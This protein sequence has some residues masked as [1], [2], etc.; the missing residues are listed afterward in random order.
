MIKY[1]EKLLFEKTE[2]KQSNILFAQWNYDKKVIPEALNAVSN[3]FPHYSLHDESHSIT[4]INNIVRVLGKEKIKNLSSIDIWLLLEASYSHDIGM[5][6]SHE[7][8]IE[9]LGSTE[10]LDFFTEIQQDS[11]NGLNE[12]AT[13]FILKNKRLEYIS[14]ELNLN[15]HDGIKFILAEFFRRKHSDRSKEII[16]N[17]EKELGLTS[18]R[19]VIPNRL[20]KIL[21]D[22]CESHTKNFE[23]VMKLPFCEV[24][25]D[26]ENSHPRF[27][28]CLL[29]IGDLLDLDN[30]RFSEVMLRTLSKT[31]IDTLSHKAKHLSIQSFRVDDKVIEV[32]AKC[33]DY[34]TASITQHWFNYLNAEISDQMLNWNYIVPYKEFGY[35]PTIGNL[36]VDLLNYEYI[37]GKKKPKF[38]VD[39]DKALELLK[40]AGIYEGA[41]QCVREILQ[42]AVDATLLKIWLDNEN[43]TD[44]KFP[45]SEFFNEIVSQHEISIEINEEDLIRGEKSWEIV[46]TDKGTG[47]SSYDLSYLMSTGSSS[48]NRKKN[49]IINS[50][51]CWLKPSGTFGIGF[52]VSIRQ[53]A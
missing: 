50:M 34:E 15:Y 16:I 10:F 53:T 49:N 21:A 41:Y 33:V 43:D 17:P 46:I 7:K 25:I 20:F 3:L 9:A 4:I 22:I 47:L 51:P 42:N 6:V 30:N 44:L 38:S 32:K 45:N 23:D 13:Q 28:A 24:G 48:K 40:G 8:L 19:G 35:L 1:L 27:I 2:G 29:R 18:P 52:Q 12:F 5:V 31:P 39:T 37:D 36:Q 14:S 26:I 11:K